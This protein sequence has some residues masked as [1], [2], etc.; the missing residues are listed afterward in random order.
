MKTRVVISRPTEVATPLLAIGMLE[1]EP[2]LDGALAEVDSALGGLIGRLVAEREITG[3]LNEVVVVH[4]PGGIAPERV[5]VV[6]LG[7]R[8]DL[9]LDRVRQAAGSVAKRVAGLKLD[10]FAATLLGQGHS[11]LGV[12]SLAQAMVEGATLATYQYTLFKTE[13]EELPRPLSELSII[14]VDGVNAPAIESG[15]LKGEIASAA[16]VMARDLVNGPANLVTPAYMVEKARDLANSFGLGLEVLGEDQMRQLGMGA[17]LGVAKG[18]AQPPYLI[19]LRYEGAGVGKPTLALVGKGVTF[20]SG[21]IS[22]KPAEGLHEMK[23]DMAGGAAVLG[24]LQGLATLRAPVNVLGIVPVTENLPSG[25]ASRPGD[26]LTASNGKTIEVLSTDA[27]GRLI[28][29]DALAYAIKLGADA[30]VDIATLTGACVVALGH[31]AAGVM[32]NDDGLVSS[33][34][35]SGEAT[36]ER[37]WRL[38]LWPPYHEQIKSDIAD[39]KNSGGR[40]GGAITGAAF[41]SNFV[42]DKPWAHLDIAGM[43]SSDKDLPYAPKGATGFG[44]RLLID[45]ARRWGEGN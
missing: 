28:L 21:G 7:K 9:S 29:A 25:T 40:P 33:L 32:G 2:V 44:A 1:G 41:L 26:V 3:K 11:A 37:V 20:D 31:H 43:A 24:A 30:M 18:S 36:G 15:S 17:L 27:E 14:D 34:E 10:R 22:I 13:K 16:T 45:F 19:V 38:P 35:G 39:I 4:S 6:G 42:G 12:E 23:Y 8:G 5:A